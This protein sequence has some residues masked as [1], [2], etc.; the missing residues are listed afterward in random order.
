QT[1]AY[2]ENVEL[3]SQDLSVTSGQL[4][5]MFVAAGT[6][7]VGA[8]AFG[9]ALSTAINVGSSRAYVTGSNVAATGNVTVDAQSETEID[10]WAVGA[11]GSLQASVAANA[12]VSVM[13]NTTEAFVGSSSVGSVGQRANALSVTANDL[14]TVR[15]RSGALG[16]AL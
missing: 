7:S 13:S 4:S 1:A 8:G 3:A 16:I 2:A 11:S 12:V 14:A 5:R 9:G 6:V 10:N 15:H